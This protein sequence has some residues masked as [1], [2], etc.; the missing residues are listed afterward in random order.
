MAKD[1]YERGLERMREL[2]SEGEKRLVEN[3]KDIAPDFARYAIEFAFGDIFSRPGL[4]LKL[5]EIVAISSLTTSGNATQQLKVHINN[6]LNVGCSRQEITEC[7]LETVIYAG[8]P[9]VMNGMSAAKEVFDA[10]GQ[11]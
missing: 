6:A 3:F 8:F 5:R 10:R 9:A 11:S 7:I 4:D 1:R 2:D